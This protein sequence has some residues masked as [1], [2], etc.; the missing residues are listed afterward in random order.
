MLITIQGS[1]RISQ[2]VGAV[3]DVRYLLERLAGN[4]ELKI[5]LPGI[6][7]SS[8]AVT[9]E[10]GPEGQYREL[11]AIALRQLRCRLRS[12]IEELAAL[13][14][15]IQPDEHDYGPGYPATRP[16]PS[17]CRS[18][19]RPGDPPLRPSDRRHG[20]AVLARPPHVVGDKP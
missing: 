11:Q 19:A 1:H 16:R 4:A 17:A 12:Y 6:D 7:R 3:V 2:L 13:S 5:S 15:T 14:V 10:D 9:V 20:R 18:T 8:M